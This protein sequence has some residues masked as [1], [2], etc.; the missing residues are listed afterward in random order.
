MVWPE[1]NTSSPGTTAL[2]VE[3]G[4]MRSIFSAGLLDGF[5]AH[6]FNPFDLYIGVSGGAFNLVTYLSGSQGTSL[7]LIQDMILHKNFVSYSRFFRGGHLLD[8]DWL[9]SSFFSKLRVRPD[10]FTNDARPLYVCVTDVATGNP[11]YIKASPQNIRNLLFASS[12]I[13]VV[14][15]GFAI[16]NGRRVLDGG[17]AEGI[18]VAQAMQ[19]GAQRIMVIRSRHRRYMKQDTFGHKYIRWKMREHP[20]LLA[21]MRRRIEI[22][23]N[24][25][26]LLRSPPENVQIVEICP[27]DDFSVRSF[28]RN[29]EILLKGYT[30][31]IA[32]AQQAIEQWSAISGPGKV[33]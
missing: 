26:A 17:I 29:K 5:L 16:V 20:A 33:I 8:L 25:I 28:S 22:H 6:K 32:A 18:P 15:R 31:G 9:V 7:Q 1:M 30:T 3:G 14:H 19:H 11:V 4:S 21:T 13:P 27:P 12:S 24:S 2:V 10:L 23:S